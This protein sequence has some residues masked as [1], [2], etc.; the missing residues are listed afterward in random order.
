MA[1][2]GKVGNVGIYI[3]YIT[4][5]IIIPVAKNVARKIHPRQ[6]SK[7]SQITIQ[8][9]TIQLQIRVEYLV[10]FADESTSYIIPHVTAST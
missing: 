4:A 8:L 2:V 6:K 3:V 10:N 5:I 7:T 9:K 1:N